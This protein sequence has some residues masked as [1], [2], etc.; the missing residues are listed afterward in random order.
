MTDSRTPQK[1]ERE[2]GKEMVTTNL[3]ILIS[4]ANVVGRR[5]AIIP[6]IDTND[7]DRAHQPPGVPRNRPQASP[8]SI[9]GLRAP[10]EA[11]D[12]SS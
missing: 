3:H 11:G 1:G 7:C 2:G 12:R 5:C 6:S 10:K 4:L 8:Y 9:S